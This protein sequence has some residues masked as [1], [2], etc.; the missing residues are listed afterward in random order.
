MFCMSFA[1]LFQLVFLSTAFLAEQGIRQSRTSHF[2]TAPDQDVSTGDMTEKVSCNQCSCFAFVVFSVG[3]DSFLR[4]EK[5]S[6][7]IRP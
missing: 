3:F 4:G 7:E 1:V 6:L 2:S 5:F